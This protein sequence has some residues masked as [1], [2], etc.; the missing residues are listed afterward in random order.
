LNIVRYHNGLQSA[1]RFL[2]DVQYNVPIA[3]DMFEA[4]V[5]YD[6]YKLNQ[7]KKK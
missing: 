2:S 1:Q 3:D 4:K 7:K 6:M 5:T